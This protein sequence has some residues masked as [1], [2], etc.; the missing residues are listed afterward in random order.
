MV[1]VV[2]LGTVFYKLVEGWS[3]I[4]SFYFTVVTLTTVGYGD[5]SPSRGVSKLFTVLF[6]LVGVGFILAVLNFMVL[7][8][9]RRM[10]GHE[11]PP[12]SR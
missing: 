10:S 4:D 3:W 2:G 6:I 7:E 8:T 12:E 5:L 11:G 1:N 9:A